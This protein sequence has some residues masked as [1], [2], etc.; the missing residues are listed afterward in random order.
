MPLRCADFLF[1][2]VDCQFS[3]W[4]NREWNQAMT[5]RVQDRI[6]DVPA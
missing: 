5:K 4:M 2:A 3:V 6:S 1:F